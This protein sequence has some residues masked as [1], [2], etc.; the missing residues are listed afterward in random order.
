MSHEN[1]INTILREPNAPYTH[2]SDIL[3]LNKYIIESI[4]D[5]YI[6]NVVHINLLSP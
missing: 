2:Q 5:S 4:R 3:F 1:K 6:A